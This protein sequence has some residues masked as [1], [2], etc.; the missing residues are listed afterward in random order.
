M[1]RKKTATPVARYSSGMHD[2][3]HG[4]GGRFGGRF[5][6]S[7]S[8]EEKDVSVDELSEGVPPAGGFCS[9]G[10]SAPVSVYEGSPDI[11][12]KVVDQ[13]ERTEP[14]VDV[15]YDHTDMTEAWTRAGDVLLVDDDAC[16]KYLRSMLEDLDSC[17]SDESWLDKNCEVSKGPDHYSDALYDA[18]E[19]EKKVWAAAASRDP[20]MEE[21]VSARLTS[22]WTED[23]EKSVTDMR[24]HAEETMWDRYSDPDYWYDG[25]DTWAEAAM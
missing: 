2:H 12:E 4:A 6:R 16:D 7:P 8:P 22:A 9:Q 18:I 15:G 17:V 5:K 25:P 11:R 10:A 20:E 21:R 14:P 19:E 23:F 24:K 1:P 3:R 13:R